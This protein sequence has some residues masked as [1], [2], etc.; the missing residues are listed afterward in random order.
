MEANTYAGAGVDVAKAERFV[1]R[2]KKKASR[3]LHAKLWHGA[4]GYAS[5]VPLG[6]DQAVALTT[7]GVGT[8]LLVAV[9]FDRVETIGIDLVAMCAND[10]ICVGARPTAFLDYFATPKLDDKQADAIIAGIIEGCDRAGLPL[11]GGETAELPGLYAESHFDLAGFA[12]G[13]VTKSQL[14]TGDKIKP[15]DVVVG[16]A[17]SGIHSNGLSLARKLVPQGHKQR[18]DLLIPTNI[19]VKPAVELLDDPAVEVHG[20][21]HITGGGWRNLFRLSDDAG[22][23]IRNPLPLPPIFDILKRE[24]S[25]D[26]LYKTFNMGM[27]LALILGAGGERAVEIFK[28]HGFAA[29]EIGRV[30][31]DSGSMTIDASAH[32][33]ADKKVKV[34]A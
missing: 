6:A 16:V 12:V 7:D 24:V 19:Y 23:E 31:E 14:I 26:E 30:T 8:K 11:V 2:L 10:L 18:A 3:D 4:G 13:T 32:F 28:K 5:V 9:E 33:G 27:G 25:A 20:I 22:F 1:D 34:S 29:A 21:A 15:G 17:S